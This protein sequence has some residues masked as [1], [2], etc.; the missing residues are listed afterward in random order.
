[1]AVMTAMTDVEDIADMGSMTDVDGIADTTN[2]TDVG[3]MTNTANATGTAN[4]TDIS[5]IVDMRGKRGLIMGVANDRSIAW[6]IA[7]KLHSAGAEL[8]F[9]YQNEVLYSRVLKLATSIGCSNLLACDVAREDDIEQAFTQLQQIWPAIDFVVHAVAFSDKAAL[10]GKY[11]QSI[12]RSN[13]LNTMLI[14]CYSFTEVAKSAAPLMPKG[15]SLLTMSYYGAEKVIPH[16]NVMG[17]AKAALETSVKYLAADLGP[18]N[19]RVNALSAGPI[20]TLAASGIGDIQYILKWNQYNSP[21]R[22]NI[23]LADVAGSAFYLLSPLSS[24][25]TGEIAHVDCGYNI[26]GMKAVDAPDIATV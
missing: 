19:I 11:Y 22:R 12:T 16:Y 14:S 13:F 26:I 5:T 2:T 21:L 24:G 10:T 1:M 3:K 8:A 7:H 18:D 25:V 4:A 15:G 17:I 23:T 20:R 6:A 9:T